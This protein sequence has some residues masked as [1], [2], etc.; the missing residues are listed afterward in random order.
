MIHLDSVHSVISTPNELD[1]IINSKQ[2]QRLKDIN[3]DTTSIYFAPFKLDSRFQHCLGTFHLSQFVP[4]ELNTLEVRLAA[5]F[6]DI[7]APPF[8]HITDEFMLKI[9]GKDHESVSSEI[10]IAFED[11]FNENGV[12]AKKISDY[13][14]GKHLRGKIINNDIDV[15]NLDNLLRWGIGSKI[16]TSPQYDPIKIIKTMKVNNNTI[17]YDC[18]EEINKWVDYRYAVYNAVYDSSNLEVS[19]MISKALE[20]A[21][22]SNSINKNFFSMTESE[23]IKYLKTINGAD[24]LIKMLESKNLFFRVIDVKNEEKKDDSVE[25]YLQNN[26]ATNDYYLHSFKSKD[27][28]ANISNNKKPHYRTAVFIHPKHKKM[29]DEIAEKIKK[30]L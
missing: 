4:D 21:F 23:A 5:L 16:I 11:F 28:K 14:V 1:A 22:E 6:H 19:A 25:H 10:I 17:I 2:M 7:G 26:F 20:I 12:S 15:D 13:I 18:N 3:L 27:V 24:E 8:T 29:K 30:L 9:I